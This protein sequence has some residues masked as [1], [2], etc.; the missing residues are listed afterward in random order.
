MDSRSTPQPELA[1]KREV[2][3]IEDMVVKN[4]ELLTENNK[5]LKKIQRA[6]AI[7]F[8]LRL[9]WIAIILGLPVLV[10]Y[11]AI[12]PYYSSVESAFQ[13]LGVDLPSIPGLSDSE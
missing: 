3:D 9:L 6:N 1:T 7:A 8:W 11:Y 2:R 12:A 10:Y 5:L 13:F 4:Q